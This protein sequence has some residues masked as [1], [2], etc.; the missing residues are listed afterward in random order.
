MEGARR[1]PSVVAALSLYNRDL[2]NGISS[3]SK[4]PSETSTSKNNVPRNI[5]IMTNQNVHNLSHK[6]ISK[7]KAQCA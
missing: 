3:P 4:E 1:D 6:V 7:S 2:R 5:S